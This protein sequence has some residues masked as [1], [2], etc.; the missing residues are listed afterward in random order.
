[1]IVPYEPLQ[2]V[3][4]M[5]GYEPTAE[6]RAVHEA[7][8]REVTGAAPDTGEM[9]PLPTVVVVAGGEQAGKSLSAAQHAHAHWIVDPI[10]WL[11]GERYEDAKPEYQAIVEMG[12]RCGTI[13]KADRPESD[14][15]WQA[16]YRNGHVIKALSSEDVTKLAREAPAGIVMCEP[17]RQTKEAFE[18]LYRRAGI[19]DEPGWL[20][21]AGTFEQSA[22]WYPQL[23]MAGKGD[24]PYRV[25]SLSIPTYSNVKRFPGGIND[26]RFRLLCQTIRDERPLDGEDIIQERFFGIPRR[27]RGMVF[28]DFSRQYHVK[29][30]AEY[31][32]GIEVGLAVDPGYANPFAVC[33]LQVVQGQIHQFDEL[34]V[35]R[36]RAA[37]V[38]SMVKNHRAFQDLT[39]VVMDIAATQHANAQDSAYEHW[40]RELGPRGVSVSGRYVTIEEG[41]R[42]LH[43]KLSMD[44]G[45]GEPFYLVHPRCKMTIFEME[46]G[47]RYHQAR[48]TGDIGSEK[49]IDEHN[50]AAKALGY[51]IV[52]RWGY[53]EGRTVLPRPKIMV[54]A[55]DRVF[56]SRRRAYAGR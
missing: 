12:E 10:V 31:I 36:T 3:F 17:G 9:A 47:Y 23:W 35:T 40:I 54:P 28:P 6:Q 4:K 13:V 25:Q 41:I 11:V 34:Y 49:P 53:A 46:E 24:N 1:V 30:S 43:D 2:T 21:V 29:E 18:T 16:Q 44:V 20:L 27:Q 7:L 39:H 8:C 22:R 15:P 42:R 56:Q 37:D 51:Y 5:T 38:L 48:T 55:Y 26:P 32:P 52:D 33:F 14:P 19:G 50:H 45:R